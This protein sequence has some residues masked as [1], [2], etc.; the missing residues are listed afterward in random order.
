VAFVLALQGGTV[1]GLVAYAWAGFGAAFGTVLITSLFWRKMNRVGA[2]A[3]MIAGGATVLIYKQI[4]T[5]GLYEMIPGV[6]AGFICIFVFN[7]FGSA[8][9]A[10]MESDFD[11]VVEQQSAGT[12]AESERVGAPRS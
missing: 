9:T 12:R 1:L 6:L 2:L 4:D 11:T 7:R 3:G 8:P 5:I 10:A